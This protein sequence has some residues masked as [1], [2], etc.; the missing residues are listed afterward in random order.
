MAAFELKDCNFTYQNLPSGGVFCTINYLPL[1]LLVKGGVSFEG[2]YKARAKA[3][4]ALEELL[5]I[6]SAPEPHKQLEA[7][8]WKLLDEKVA[9]TVA[10]QLPDAVQ[11]ALDRFGL[12]N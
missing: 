9:A 11:A 12:A 5:K 6:Y 1:G 7:L 8:F 3:E 4:E 10:E 2:A